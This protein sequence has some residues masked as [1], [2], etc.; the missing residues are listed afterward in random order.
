LGGLTGIACLYGKNRSV[1]SFDFPHEMWGDAWLWVTFAAVALVL[2]A[3]NAS[4]PALFGINMEVVPDDMR[5]FA[6]GLE[7]TVRNILGY[8]FATL[9]PGIV[10]D[11]SI[12]FGASMEGSQ[13]GIGLAFVLSANFLDYFILTRAKHAAQQT[14]AAQRQEALTMLRKALQAEDVVALKKAVD[15]SRSVD[16]HQMPDGEAVLGM[17]N[18]AIGTFQK[19][20]SKAFQGAVAFTATREELYQRVLELERKNVELQEQLRAVSAPSE[21]STACPSTRKYDEEEAAT[22]AAE[23]ID[24]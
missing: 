1:D 16:L 23:K 13:L 2:A 7:M 15:F 10:M 8:A 4:V 12:S 11:I 24:V 22:D 21:L 5:S 3:R 9:L 17:A 18:Q 6:S 20:G 19:T 14:L